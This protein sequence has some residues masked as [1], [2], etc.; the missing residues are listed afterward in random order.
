MLLTA[1]YLD[2]RPETVSATF[3]LG[4]LLDT[5]FLVPTSGL[6][7]FFPLQGTETNEEDWLFYRYIWTVTEPGNLVAAAAA[8]EMYGFCK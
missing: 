5:P 7:K 8:L 3:T 6:I 2:D 4:L 1:P